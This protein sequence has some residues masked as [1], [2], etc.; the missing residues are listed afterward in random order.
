VLHALEV[1]PVAASI[2]CKRVIMGKRI[3]DVLSVVH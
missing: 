3:L 2:G 1:Q